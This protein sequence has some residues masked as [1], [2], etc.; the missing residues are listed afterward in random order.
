MHLKAELSQ[1]TTDLGGGGYKQGPGGREKQ[2]PKN[3]ISLISL[4][5]PDLYDPCLGPSLA[6]LSLATQ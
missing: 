3:F 5:L 2:I 6:I 1:G 4:D